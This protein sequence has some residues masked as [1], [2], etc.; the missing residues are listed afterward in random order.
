MAANSLI[1][2]RGLAAAKAAFQALP[3]IVRERM[4]EATETTSKEVARGGQARLLASPSIVTRDLYNAVKWAINK[5]TGRG[6]AGIAD[7]TFTVKEQAN[8]AR[9]VIG[10][11]RIRVRGTVVG[12]RLD[13]PS[14]RAHFVEFGTQKMRAEPFMI[15][16]AEAEKGPYL[17]R[18]KRAG[19][20]I[21]QDMAKI[22]LRNL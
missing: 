18:A 14:R 9:G 6:K 15:P 22:G 8:F 2:V 10:G 4:L 20:S 17:E 7:E 3:Q 16:A 5:K 1:S 12:N 19:K 21:E 11:R 13:R